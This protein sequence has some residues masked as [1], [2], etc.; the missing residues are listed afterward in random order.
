MGEIQSL[1]RFRPVTGQPTVLKGFAQMARAVTD[2]TG[3]GREIAAYGPDWKSEV[4]RMRMRI[5]KERTPGGKDPLAIKTGRG[6]LMDI[7]FVAQA[8]CL[9]HGWTEPN[10]LAAIQRGAREGRLPR[11]SA[12]ILAENYRR[13]MRIER[14]LRRWSF[15][16][17][18]LLPDDP[19]PFYRVAAR[20]GFQNSEVFQE[21][22]TGYR[23]A[24]RA[25]Y[26]RYF[27]VEVAA[28]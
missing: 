9:E 1:S 23:A 13:L 11:D 25:E 5:E 18:S 16:P 22:V 3:P 6:G 26:A 4:H 7:E 2:F 27:N 17:E 24:I 10:T 19:A 15:E 12:D 20:C 8:L 14:I 21:A 28:P